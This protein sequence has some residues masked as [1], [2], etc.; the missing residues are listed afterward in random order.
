VSIS[1]LN[2]NPATFYFTV[3]LPLQYISVVAM[4]TTFPPAAIKTWQYLGTKGGLEKNL[5]LNASNPLPKP[6][7]NQHLIQ[8][9]A[10]ALNPIDYKI[11][12]LPL[13]G[14]FLVSS[15]KPATPCNDVVGRIVTPASGSPFKRGDLVFGASGSSPFAASGLSQFTLC[16]KNNLVA[17]PERL[18]LADAAATPV[19]GLTA[20]QTI[21]PRVKKGD[22]IFIN[23]GSGGTG[24]YGIQI[25]KALGCHVTT[26]CSTPNVEL[27]KSL[28][29]DEVVDYKKGSVARALKASGV[30]FD[31]VVDNVGGGDMEL[32]WKCH[33]YTKPGAA[34]ILV[35]GAPSLRHVVEMLKVW[36]LPGF[37]GGGK[38]KL[39]GF[40]ANP[41][42]EDMTQI[43]AWMMEGK[44][45]AVIDSKFSFEEAPKAFERLKTGRARGK[46]VVD[47]AL[48]TYEKAWSG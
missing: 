13:V 24:V 27:C 42:Q 19:A 44:V 15:S 17:V 22:K 4:A 45:G 35:A 48:E 26:S 25:A 38:R 39:E 36:T 16:E 31:H 7:E 21:V 18:S 40:F 1:S 14:R 20:Y 9:I 47:V 29:A 10:T 37:L 8:V 30:K 32:Y 6:K 46:I 12:E 43:G 41:N 5:T 11:V 2:F 33:E 3:H 23:G 28:G 34:Y